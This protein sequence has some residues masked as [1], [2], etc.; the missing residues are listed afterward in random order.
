MSNRAKMIAIKP[1]ALKQIEDPRKRPPEA[2]E[3]LG[4]NVENFAHPRWE[5]SFVRRTVQ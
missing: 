2:A 1:F 4:Q 5:F 3:K